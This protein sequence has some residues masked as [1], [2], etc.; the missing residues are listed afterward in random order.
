[1]NTQS[2][3]KGMAITSLVM[4]ILAWLG[5]CCCCGGALFA[6]NY[7]G[8]GMATAGIVLGIISL[9]MSLLGILIWLAIVFAWPCA[10]VGAFAHI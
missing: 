9:I 1:M 10:M 4:G 3:G 2:N 5:H 8:C 7:D 6:G